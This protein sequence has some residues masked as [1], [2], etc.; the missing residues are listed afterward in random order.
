MD[1]QFNF[2]ESWANLRC[3]R[4]QVDCPRRLPILTLTATLYNL[5]VVKPPTVDPY[6]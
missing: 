6:T 5:H 4:R 2:D 1:K 3:Q